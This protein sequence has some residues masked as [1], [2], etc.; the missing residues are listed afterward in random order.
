MKLMTHYQ[1]PKPSPMDRKLNIEKALGDIFLAEDLGY[2]AEVLSVASGKSAIQ[3][4]EIDLPEAVKEDLLILLDK[5]RI[6][7]LFGT[8]KTIAWEDRLI[9]FLP[10]EGYEV[11]HV[12]RNMLIRAGKSSELEPF[13]ALKDYL[14]EIGDAEPEDTI[15]LIEDVLEEIEHGKISAD[16]LSGAAKKLS[17]ESKMGTIIAVLKGAGVI[18][19]CLRNPSTLRYEVNSFFTKCASHNKSTV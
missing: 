19:P 11:P 7:I 5:E 6:L 8:S 10:D 3:N 12:I 15:S 2:I 13:R 16:K 4:S 14:T 1:R 17:L 18:S 9:M